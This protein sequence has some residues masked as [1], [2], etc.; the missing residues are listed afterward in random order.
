MTPTAGRV[1]ELEGRRVALRV[2]LAEAGDMRPGSLVER[3]RQCGQPG[4]HCA[5][6]G[7]PG[8]GPSWS[9]TREVDGKTVTRVIPAA[10]VDQTRA[11]IA[12]YRRFRTLTRDLVE[13]SAAVCDAR[14][15]ASAATADAAAKKGAARPPARPRS[16]ER[17]R[18]S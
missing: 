11:Q 13:A 12:E 18:R 2:R 4:C 17:S 5:Q 1:G 15:D 7:A 10:A 14:L 6:A 9:L 8:H 3:Y 16:P